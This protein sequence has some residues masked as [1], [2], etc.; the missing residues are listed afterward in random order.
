MKKELVKDKVSII[1]PMYNVEDYVEDFCKSI[2]NQI[3]SNYEVIIVDDG[4]TD[5]SAEIVKGFCKKDQ[6]FKLYQK[7]NGGVSSARNYGLNKADGEYVTMYDPDDTIPPKALS[8]LHDAIINQKVDMAMGNMVVIQNGKKQP[9][10]SLQEMTN[11]KQVRSCDPRLAWC[12]QNGPRLYK[13]RIIIDN[14]LRYDESMVA[15]EDLFFLFAYYKCITEVATTNEVVYEYYIRNISRN[16]ASLSFKLIADYAKHLELSNKAASQIFDNN[17]WNISDKE[18]SHLRNS[19]LLN[20]NI[21]HMRG[22]LMR[23]YR[24]M[25]IYSDEEVEKLIKVIKNDFTDY[26]MKVEFDMELSRKNNNDLL[27]N[28]KV[29]LSKEEVLD[30][31]IYTFVITRAFPKD[32]INL[33]LKSL[34][35]QECPFFEVLVD[36]AVADNIDEWYLNQKNCRVIKGED[37]ATIK[38]KAVKEAKGKYIQFFE[39]ALIPK[40]SCYRDLYCREEKKIINKSNFTLPIMDETGK[41]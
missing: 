13:N 5:S 18:L 23:D 26:L 31:L 15:G 22:S 4:S 3:Y 6:R 8:S 30:S 19:F 16:N 1:V 21:R 20:L 2:L 29:F 32:S 7:E 9:I 40:E 10:K 38:N 28:E 27:R 35:W 37:P 12:V 24:K 34:Y 41:K 25:W 11:C 33:L 17:K 39:E 36:E 14:N